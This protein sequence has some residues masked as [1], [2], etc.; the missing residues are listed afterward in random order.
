MSKKDYT[1][2]ATAIAYAYKDS[3]SNNEHLG[4]FSVKMQL[5]SLLKKDN[6]RFDE[7]KFQAYIDKINK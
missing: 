7:I 1:L 5:L 6:P 2:I 4:I 3:I